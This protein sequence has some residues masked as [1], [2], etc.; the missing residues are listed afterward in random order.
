MNDLLL[1]QWQRLIFPPAGV[2][3]RAGEQLREGNRYPDVT[4]GTEGVRRKW[5]N[6]PLYRTALPPARTGATLPR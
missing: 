5:G 3:V 2:P 4:G 6:S 1:T